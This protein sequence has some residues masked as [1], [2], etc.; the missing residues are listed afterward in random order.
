MSLW[1]LRKR[2]AAQRVTG[3][4]TRITLGGEFGVGAPQ[5]ASAFVDANCKCSGIYHYH[6]GDIFLPG[7]QSFVFEPIFETPI[8]SIWGGGGG[9]QGF[10]IAGAGNSFFNPIQPPQVYSLQMV[11]T[12]GVGGL[13]AGQMALQPLL[14]DVPGGGA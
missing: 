3:A 4:Q 11:K 2:Y 9:A 7:A 6:E 12:S 8:K 5:F 14:E 10:L 1:P 13:Q